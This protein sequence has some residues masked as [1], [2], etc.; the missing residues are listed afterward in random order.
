MAAGRRRH[1]GRRPRMPSAYGVCRGRRRSRGL[2]PPDRRSAR[3]EQ[4]SRSS[5][6]EGGVGWGS[7]TVVCS[8]LTALGG[9]GDPAGAADTCPRSRHASREGALASRVGSRVWP[10]RFS[11]TKRFVAATGVSHRRG[12]AARFRQTAQ[13]GGKCLTLEPNS[14]SRQGSRDG[15]RCQ[16]VHRDPL[17][18]AGPGTGLRRWADQA[19]ASPTC[20]SPSPGQATSISLAGLPVSQRRPLHR[21]PSA[22]LGGAAG[23]GP[24]RRRVAVQ[25]EPELRI[26]AFSFGN[27]SRAL[28]RSR[29]I[30]WRRL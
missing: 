29:A 8:G 14:S 4:R 6:Q 28:F 15:T 22:S 2:A 23:G 13:V 10:R 30:R 20:V 11:G 19:P 1:G 24:G 18:H 27:C 5:P 25:R 7:Q 17:L 3:F 21:A 12:V 26:R 9:R 16:S